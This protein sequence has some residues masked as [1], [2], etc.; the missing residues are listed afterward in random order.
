MPKPCKHILGEPHMVS[1]QHSEHRYPPMCVC[2]RSSGRCGFMIDH[3]DLEVMAQAAY[4]RGIEYARAG[5]HPGDALEE[6]G[7]LRRFFVAGYLSA[8]IP[9]NEYNADPTTGTAYVPEWLVD[10]ALLEW[11]MTDDFG[12]SEYGDI[13]VEACKSDCAERVAAAR[14]DMRA[15]IPERRAA[16]GSACPC[17]ISGSQREC[18]PVPVSGRTVFRECPVEHLL[19]V[20]S[21]NKHL[22][23]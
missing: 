17:R 1:W 8:Q 15:A 19:K 18:V 3:E 22:A 10:L 14:G 4:L 12:A 7:D 16:G 21:L 20:A 5:E 23:E 2:G 9:V 6:S 11:S 13:T